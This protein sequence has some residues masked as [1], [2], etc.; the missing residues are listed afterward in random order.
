MIDTAQDTG[1]SHICVGCLDKAPPLLPPSTTDTGEQRLPRCRS[2]G[3]EHSAKVRLGILASTVRKAEG[4]ST[5]IN[6]E[7]I[8]LVRNVFGQFLAAATRSGISTAQ[9]LAL[10]RTPSGQ[11]N[12][13]D[14]VSQAHQNLAR[15]KAIGILSH[16]RSQQESLRQ[17]LQANEG[18]KHCIDALT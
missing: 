17:I 12:A 3:A 15:Q 11:V 13:F 7:K 14:F 4:L 6:D 2:H 10:F 9:N 5:K 16:A 8:G 18:Y 1:S